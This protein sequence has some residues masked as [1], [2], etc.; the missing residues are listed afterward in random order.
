MREVE[1]RF[2]R[3]EERLIKETQDLKEDVK[4][5]LDA[6]T[7][8]SRAGVRVAGRATSRRTQRA[9]RVDENARA[10]RHDS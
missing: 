7:K 1:R 9:A 5:R 2:A 3:L 10:A 6:L 8:R 4:R